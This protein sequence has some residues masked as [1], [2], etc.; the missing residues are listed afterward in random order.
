MTDDVVVFDSLPTACGRRFCLATL[1][2]PTTLNALS[3]DMVQ[4]LTPMLRDWF[5]EQSR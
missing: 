3:L 4:A 2:V 5:M 1:N